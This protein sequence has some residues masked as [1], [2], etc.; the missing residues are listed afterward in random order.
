MSNVQFLKFYAI[1]TIRYC[2]REFII[3]PSGHCNYQSWSGVVLHDLVCHWSERHARLTNCNKLRRLCFTKSEIS[4][5]YNDGRVKILKF[6]KCDWQL[7]GFFKPY[8]SRVH[9]FWDLN[10]RSIYN[11]FSKKKIALVGCYITI[12][13]RRSLERRAFKFTIFV[14]VNNT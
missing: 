10:T 5:K 7:T 6:W 9:F 1:I 12:H 13:G 11:A 2:T 8:K 3:Y 4:T 14:S